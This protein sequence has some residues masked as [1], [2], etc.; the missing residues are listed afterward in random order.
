MLGLSDEGLPHQN[1]LDIR[2]DLAGDLPSLRGDSH[3]LLRSLT[4][5]LENAVIYQPQ[6]GEVYV[7]TGIAGPEELRAVNQLPSGGTFLFVE[8]ADRGP[9]IS[10]ENKKRIF[11]PFFTTRAKG[12]G[13]GLSIVKGIIEGHGG[14]ITENGEPGKGARF[15]ILL[16]SAESQAE[17]DLVER[18][19]HRDGPSVACPTDP[20]ELGPHLLSPGG[21]TV[22]LAWDFR[23]R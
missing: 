4:E 13:L 7:R 18:G 11:T 6:G 21:L 3:K 12:M 23:R 20:G 10:E 1:Q 2:C 19:G 14:A 16:P 15:L 8:V 5:L 17:S 22:E 9:G